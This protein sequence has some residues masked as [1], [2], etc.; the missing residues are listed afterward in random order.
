MVRLNPIKLE[1]DFNETMHQIATASSERIQLQVIAHFLERIKGYETES[2]SYILQLFQKL[3]DYSNPLLYAG[4]HP[5]PFKKFISQIEEVIRLLELNVERNEIGLKLQGYRKALIQLFRWV[6]EHNEVETLED[7]LAPLSL[8]RRSKNKFSDGILVPVVEYSQEA[9]SGR[10]RRLKIEIIGVSK[11]GFELKPTFGVIGAE[12]GSFLVEVECASGRLL[13]E[14]R[15]RKNKQWKATAL[16]ELSHAWH[17]GRS[18][19][20]ALAGAFY[21]EMLQAEEQSEY[22]KLNPAVCITGDIDKIGNVIP[23]DTKSLHQKVEAAFFS[24][25][26]VLVVP[27]AQLSKTLQYV[28]ELQRQFPNRYLPVVGVSHLQ[29]LFF[30]RRISLHKKTGILVHNFRRVWKRRLSVV[31]VFVF[32][33]LIGIITAL[34][35]EPIDRNPVL[36]SYEGEMLYVKNK[37]GRTIYSEKVGELEVQDALAQKVTPVV[38][39]D[40]DKDGTNE[41]LRIEYEQG[42]TTHKKL[43]LL[44]YNFTDTLWSR[45][46]I[47]EVPFESH[48]N[49]NPGNYNI[50]DIIVFDIDQDGEV[51]ILAALSHRPFF[52]SILGVFNINDGDLEKYYVTPGYSSLQGI[53]DIDKDGEVEIILG[54]ELKGY[55]IIT[56]I[57]LPAD[58]ETSHAPLGLRYSSTLPRAKEKAIIGFPTS[59]VAKIKYFEIGDLGRFG[60]IFRIRV[61]DRDNTILLTKY[62]PLER[63]GNKT[64]NM[65]FLYEFDWRLN[66]KRIGSNDNYDVISEQLYVEDKIPFLPDAKYLE[67]LKDSLLYWNGASFQMEPTLNK[68]YLEWVGKDSSYYKEWYFA[69]V[70]K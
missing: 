33:V 22:F 38:F 46:L 56:M 36:A 55:R 17:S 34:V 5:E 54:T 62:D 31:S 30:D 52:P 12:V 63:N 39:V 2:E 10:L 7:A 44:N 25:V 47:F 48:P 64:V 4:I 67:T 11:N 21:C 29:E 37:N 53:I 42:E 32:I 3:P 9:K 65:A 66:I 59:M 58:F 18:A 6:G 40:I 69:E 51:E 28:E 27:V 1:I 70:P 16:F 23:V 14:N 57:I 19:N 13:S 45:G 8:E 43:Y 50:D 24:W 26:H 20:L 35:I 49:L 15:N 61:Y 41:I 60:T 68:K